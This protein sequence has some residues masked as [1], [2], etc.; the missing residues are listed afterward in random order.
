MM[1][2][3]K[4]LDGVEIISFSGEKDSVIENIAFDSRKVKPEILSLLL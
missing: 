3:G 4:V 2:L 1:E